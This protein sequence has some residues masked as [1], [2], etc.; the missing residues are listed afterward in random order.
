MK[1]NRCL[2]YFGVFGV[3]QLKTYFVC[4]TATSTLG[5]STV[6][7]ALNTA[8]IMSDNSGSEEDEQ[9][10]VFQLVDAELDVPVEM[11]PVPKA[12]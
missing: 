5:Y 10:V 11:T 4:Y 12:S 3:C 2:C 7:D 8:E 1:V 9:V 6:K